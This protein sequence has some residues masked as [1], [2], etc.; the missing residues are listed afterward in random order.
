MGLIMVVLG[1]S[2]RVSDIQAVGY[3]DIIYPINLIQKNIVTVYW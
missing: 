3:S 1:Q 2:D